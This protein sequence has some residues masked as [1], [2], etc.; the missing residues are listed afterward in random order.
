MHDLT[1]S[2]NLLDRSKLKGLRGWCIFLFAALVGLGWFAFISAVLADSLF[3]VGFCVGGIILIGGLIAVNALVGWVYSQVLTLRIGRPKLAA[4]RHPLGLGESFDVVL[5][6]AVKSPTQIEKLSITLILQEWV[7]YT[8]GTTTHTETHDHL[9][10]RF[11][12]PGGSF[13]AGSMLYE[14]VSFQIPRGSMPHFEDAHN[15]LRWFI[16]VQIEQS[17]WLNL[18]QLYELEVEPRLLEEDDNGW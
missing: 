14:Q 3:V 17:G 5:D 15:K 12:K 1:P 13:S 4:S 16:D 8:V 9:I 2:G 6:A 7:Q 11:E 18:Y 10:E